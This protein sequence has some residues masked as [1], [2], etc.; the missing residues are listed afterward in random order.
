MKG[1]LKNIILEN[2][3]AGF[4][5]IVKRENYQ[6]PLNP[7]LIISLI[8]AR[9]CGKTYLLYD[10]MKELISKGISK[11]RIIFLNFEDER[12]N[13]TKENLDLILQAYQE[14]FPD[15]ELS[16]CYFFFDEI[17]NINGWEKFIR[18]IFD[19]KSKKIF[20]TGSNSKLLSTEIATELRGRTI[21]FTIYP[22]SFKEFL[23]SSKAPG[24]SNTSANKA[25]IINLAEC[26]LSDG[27]FPELIF[28]DKPLK[29]KILQ[30]YFNV[31]IYR[32][33]VERYKI[34]G[35]D[36]LKFFIKKI[37]ASVTVPFSVNKVYND[38]RSMG[39]KV[40]N[41]YLYEYIDY[42]N[43]VFLTR[44]ISKFS[45]SDIK[46]AKSD[47]KIYIIDNG[48]LSAIDY[49]LAGNKGKLL[50]NLAAI[51]L[52][53]Q[54][55]EVFYF[56]EKYECDFIIKKDNE[57]KAMQVAYSIKEDKTRQRELRGLSE[58]CKFINTNHA[59]IL[60]FDEDDFIKYEDIKID[61]TP[62]YK[63]FL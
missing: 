15:I 1:I 25:K 29:T 21:S 17:Q 16:T 27:G 22:Y 58:A 2:Q 44:N 43:S 23:F 30:Q 47:K 32:D 59:T 8:G 5:D 38:L 48:L 4:P 41:K 31:M 35:A 12:L 40:S 13:L 33:L 51:E 37:I 7:D 3:E 57:L 20:I 50:E 36:V 62:F 19:T 39:Y 49:N 28:F 9:R 63:Y 55:Y 61:I 60:T 14:L 54:H 6:I 42:C 53:K 46:Q 18:R 34:S 26:F 56:K 45:F 52:L 24:D 10:C 11:E